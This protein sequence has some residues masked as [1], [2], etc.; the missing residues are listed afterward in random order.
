MEVLGRLVSIGYSDFFFERLGSIA[1]GDIIVIF[2]V[3]LTD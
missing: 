1:W 2:L 3:F